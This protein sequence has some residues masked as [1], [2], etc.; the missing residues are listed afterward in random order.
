[1]CKKLSLIYTRDFYPCMRKCLNCVR[2]NFCRKI[3]LYTCNCI[4]ISW[5]YVRVKGQSKFFQ[6]KGMAITWDKSD[7]ISIFDFLFRIDPPPPISLS[8]LLYVHKVVVKLLFPAL[9][10]RTVTILWTGI[11]PGTPVYKTDTANIGLSS[12]SGSFQLA[13][14]D[15]RSG[16]RPSVGTCQQFMFISLQFWPLPSSPLKHLCKVRLLD[17]VPV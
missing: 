17:T 12:F 9:W 14:D 11:E 1:M 8:K 13:C 10:L 2:R 15:E 3:R 4:L 16:S 5:T 7:A 6:L